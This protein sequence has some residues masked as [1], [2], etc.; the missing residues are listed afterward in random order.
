MTAAG[1]AV[2]IVLVGGRS[3]RLG[4]ADTPPGG[5]PA[6]AFGGRTFLEWI[7]AAV[8]AE[9]DHVLVVAAPGQPLPPLPPAVEVVRDS[10]PGAG[11]LSAI[12]DGLAAAA[13]LAAR[14]RTALICA[15]DAPLLRREVVRLL[16]AR[17][18]ATEAKWVVPLHAGHPQVLLSAVAVDLGPRIE[19]YLATGRRDPRG[20][21]ELLVAE[22]P[23]LV[24]TVTAAE[25]AAVDAAADSLFDV[26]TPAD[27]V[28][29]RDRGI[30]PSAP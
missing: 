2:G 16:V 6:V 18:L 28:R 15:G 1:G 30:P 19:S 20:L 23:A 12:R 5:K 29:L 14:P 7:V 13:R 3:R 21:L 22:S 26:D 11:P 4:A 9:V 10:L 25:L 27:L 17:G 8:G 24:E